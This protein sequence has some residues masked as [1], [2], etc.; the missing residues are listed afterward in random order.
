MSCHV[1]HVNA[2]LAN[3]KQ[4][5]KQ[6]VQLN[7]SFPE[8]HKAKIVHLDDDTL[9]TDIVVQSFTDRHVIIITQIG[10]MGTIISAEWYVVE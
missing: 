4:A 5:K 7:M 9:S 1:C 8:L 10:K 6:R 2:N 3:K